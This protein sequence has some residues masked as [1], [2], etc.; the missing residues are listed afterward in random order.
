[1]ELL[2][3]AKG[4]PFD[5]SLPGNRVFITF[6]SLKLD[7]I[8]S[9]EINKLQFPPEKF[10]CKDSVVYFYLPDGA[11]NAKLSNS[12]FEK[13]LKVIATGRNVNTINKMLDILTEI[14]K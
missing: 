12:F 5:S 11:K 1:T 7:R 14:E 3:V 2:E 10:Y 8:N 6:L 4:N 13:K 9:Q